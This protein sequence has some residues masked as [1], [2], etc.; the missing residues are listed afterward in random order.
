MS[1]KRQGRAVLEPRAYSFDELVEILPMSDEQIRKHERA[2]HLI[3][4]YSGTK[5]VYT[6]AEVDRFLNSLPDEPKALQAS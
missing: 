5:K 2:G 6:A 4:K 1:T 3:P